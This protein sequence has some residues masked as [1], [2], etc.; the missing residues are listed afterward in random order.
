MNVTILGCGPAGLM[1]AHGAV[2]AGANIKVLSKRRKSELFGAQYLHAPIPGATNDEPITVEYM[3]EGN[4]IDYK[5]KVYGQQWEGSVSPDDLP[6]KHLAWDIRET[7]DNLWDMYAHNIEDI[8]LTPGIVANLAHPGV[9][10]DIIIST[11]P[12]PALCSRGHT[13]GAQ[14]IVAAG[15]AP[16]RGIRIPYTAPPN[17]VL[18]NGLPAPSWYRLSNIFDHLTAEWSMASLRV[19]PPISSA[20]EVLKPLFHNCDCLPDIHHVG[21]Y[22]EWKKGVLSHESYSVAYGLVERVMAGIPS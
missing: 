4:V 15:D 12:R 11:I 21:R 13:F 3:L 19:A 5:H 14:K 16:A 6:G 18:C 7:Y 20:A 17:T 8:D 22:G 1:A 9:G 2:H 10:A